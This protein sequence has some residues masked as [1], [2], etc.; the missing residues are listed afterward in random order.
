[1]KHLTTFFALAA[2]ALAGDSGPGLKPAAK[3]TEYPQNA[4]GK[5][6]AIGARLLSPDQVSSAFATD[7]ERGYVVVE[8]ALYPKEGKL[9]I[10][11]GDFSL[12]L[13]GTDLSARA[14]SPKLIASTL[15]RAASRDRDITVH[16][17]V[18]VGYETGGGG[19]DPVYGTTRRG[20][21]TTSTGVGVGIG[22][23][24]Q[25]PASTDRD[26]KTMEAELSEQQ[27]P[28]TVTATAVAGYLYFPLKAKSKTAAYDLE[29]DSAHGKVVLHFGGARSGSGA[30]HP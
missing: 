22:G 4:E 1:M 26:R 17:Q 9:D 25:G 6:V 14:A 20:G 12:R 7:L 24:G 13:A 29:Y 10:G 28:E 16:P 21:W 8:V 5:M 3:A 27:L 30:P 15:Q 23:R 2:A 19:Y 11:P 18:G